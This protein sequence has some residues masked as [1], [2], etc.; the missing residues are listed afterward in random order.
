[1]TARPL[2]RTPLWWCTC[3]TS[4]L[5]RSDAGTSSHTRA[6]RRHPPLRLQPPQVVAA[7]LSAHRPMACTSCTTFTYL[8]FCSVLQAVPVVGSVLNELVRGT[9]VIYITGTHACT[10]SQHWRPNRT[11]PPAA[12]LHPKQ[13][14]NETKRCG[15]SAREPMPRREDCNL[16]P[17]QQQKETRAR[18]GSP[19]ARGTTFVS[20]PLP[21][22]GVIN[23][24][25][26]S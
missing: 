11:G 20:A 10:P 7:L 23:R 24:S 21:P 15:R 26:Q 12:G 6:L 22:V 25:K 18:L 2:S 16:W 4:T 1:V 3:N 5:T 14:S 13:A 19:L 8:V 9:R 17:L